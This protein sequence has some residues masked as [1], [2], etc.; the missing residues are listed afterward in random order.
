MKFGPNLV[1][2]F[3]DCPITEDTNLCG[4]AERVATGVTL[5]AR[6]D[7]A[8]LMVP[9]LLAGFLAASAAPA[10]DL[11][12]FQASG[13][14]TPSRSRVELP[15]RFLQGSGGDGG[16]GG[17]GGGGGGGSGG[18]A[19]HHNRGGRRLRRRGKSGE[20]D[21]G[22][23]T[24]VS[25]IVGCFLCLACLVT[26]MKGIFKDRAAR[27]AAEARASVAPSELLS[28]DDIAGWFM[29]VCFPFGFPGFFRREATGPDTMTERVFCLVCPCP[30]KW[31]EHKTRQPG[32]HQL[33]LHGQRTQGPRK[34]LVR[35]MRMQRACLHHEALRTEEAESSGWR[36]DHNHHHLEH[37]G[38]ASG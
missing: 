2:L 10:P 13:V 32:S 21:E 31:E 33:L 1:R 6:V 25:I 12:V 38:S 23:W 11:P 7:S 37:R 14:A 30:I 5:I 28:T 29:C 17:G 35:Q 16:E 4:L 19:R 34:V 8:V 15:G 9:L 36:P 26:V 24:I 20:C 27:I 22:C 18:G 3:E